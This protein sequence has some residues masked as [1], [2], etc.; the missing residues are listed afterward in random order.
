MDNKVLNLSSF[1]EVI[2]SPN[3]GGEFPTFDQIKKMG[4]QKNKNEMGSSYGMMVNRILYVQAQTKLLHWQT[5]SVNQHKNLDKFHKDFLALSDQLVE[6]VA[7]KYG[8]PK[9]SG[10]E[11]CINIQ[12]Y[13]HHEEGMTSYMCYLYEL[14]ST[15]IKSCFDK[16]KDSEI[17]NIIDEIVASIDHYTY[18]FSFNK[19]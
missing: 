9:L 10:D 18:L 3:H 13:R 7:G 8:R 6:V 15:E 12:N 11:C 16:N 14:F 19:P 4:H 5:F 2:G 1:G 17:L